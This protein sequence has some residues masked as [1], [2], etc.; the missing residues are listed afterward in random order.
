LAVIGA[1]ATLLASLGGLVFS[2]LTWRQ[3]T[4]AQT[5]ERFSRSTEQLGSDSIAMRVGAV[6]SFARLMRDSEADRE[7]I[8]E[9]LSSFVA[10][11]AAQAPPLSANEETRQVPADLSAAMKVLGESAAIRPSTSPSFVLNEVDLSGY[12][13]ESFSMPRADLYRAD[14]TGA[15][16]AGADLTGTL[17][18]AA[19]LTGADL[20]GADLTG[21]DLTN[22]ILTAVTCSATRT[23]WPEDFQPPQCGP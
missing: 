13:L 22:T 12:T 5:S 10:V 23:K 17:L 8:V 21:A 15:N 3:A 20:F 7:A 16:L 19:D 11:Q 18:I 9:V 4:D 2:A 1:I 14:L 6:Y